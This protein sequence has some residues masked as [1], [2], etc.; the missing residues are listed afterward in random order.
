MAAFIAGVAASVI[1]SLLVTGF[2][3]IGRSQRARLER[4][5]GGVWVE[6]IYGK[7]DVEYA[8]QIERLDIVRQVEGFRGR[9]VAG[10]I[11]RVYDRRSAAGIGTLRAY[12]V[13]GRASEGLEVDYFWSTAGDGSDGT[14]LLI[15]SNRDEMSGEYMRRNI[16]TTGIPI[17]HF[18]VRRIRIS[19]R[20]LADV[21]NSGSVVPDRL[22]EVGSWPSWVKDACTEVCSA[23]HAPPRVDHQPERQM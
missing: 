14:L 6:G 8:G 19:S 16:S 22:R 20:R 2:I 23:I 7:D 15:H 21:L 17:E 18:P 11:Y 9:R 1:A 12:K 13:R 10:K 3:S 4:G 5:S